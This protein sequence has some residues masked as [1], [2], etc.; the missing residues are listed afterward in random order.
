MTLERSDTGTETLLVAA[1][2]LGVG[3][4]DRW[5]EAL[6]EILSRP[7]PLVTLDLGGVESVDVT[8]FQ[9]LLAFQRSLKAQ[10]SNLL[11]R[12]LPPGHEVETK[13]SRV[14]IPLGRHFLFVEPSA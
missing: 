13:A 9:I 11:L 2:A 10:E 12:T 6:K 1:G 5:A 7:K 4:A 8:F 14:G 3:E